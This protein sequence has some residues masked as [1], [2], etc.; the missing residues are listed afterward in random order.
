MIIKKELLSD[1]E[2]KI[3]KLI[4]SG[5]TIFEI[6]NQLSLSIPKINACRIGLLEKME[7]KNNAGLVLYAILNDLV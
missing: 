6:A 5:N 7:V 3:L 1:L 2:L 4:S